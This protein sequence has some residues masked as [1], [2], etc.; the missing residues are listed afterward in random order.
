MA[1]AASKLCHDLVSMSAFIGRTDY[2]ILVTS[3]DTRSRV[4]RLFCPGRSEAMSGC[5][6]MQ[7]VESSQS[8]QWLCNQR[9]DDDLVRI[10]NDTRRKWHSVANRKLDFSFDHV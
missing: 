1:L 2:D 5:D 8:V 7:S 3:C 9:A 4:F 6:G 10:R